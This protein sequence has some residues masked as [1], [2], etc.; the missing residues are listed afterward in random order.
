MLCIRLIDIIWYMKEQIV[1]VII[2][3]NNWEN[4]HIASNAF[5]VL[6]CI[7]MEWNS[8]VKYVDIKYVRNSIWNELSISKKWL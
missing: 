5:D 3:Y 8:S 6:T 1:G 4:T 7:C 2:S